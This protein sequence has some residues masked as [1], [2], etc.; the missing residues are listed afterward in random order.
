MFNIILKFCGFVLLPG[1]LLAPA[2]FADVLR[3]HENGPL[4]GIF[5]V[6]DSTEGAHLLRAGERAWDLSIT[7]ASHSMDDSQSV[8]TLYLDGETTR[9]ELR[10]RLGIGTRMDVGLELPYIQHQA[11]HLDSVIDSWHNLFGLPTGH[12]PGREQNVLDFRYA[13]EA[14]Q[15]VIVDSSSKG[16]GDARLFGG[17][18]LFSTERHQLAFRFGVKFPT[19]DSGKLHGSGGTDL[20]LGLAGDVMNLFGI[21]NLTGFYRIHAIH[22]GEP[23]LLAD[24]YEK[25]ASFISTGVGFQVSDRL[26][27]RLQGASRSALYQSEIH[28]LGG[29]ATTVTFGG[30]IRISKNYELS[31][32]VSEDAD[33][34][35]APDVAFQIALRYRE[36]GGQ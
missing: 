9:V 6:P 24:R 7:H 14:G 22:I 16:I 8:E 20:S 27:L 2:A 11:G 12:R 34:E 31:L 32:G 18:R 28:S 21:S 5:G 25:W 17:L 35:T 26:E 29:N 10:F 13:D 19:G 15:A 33:A 3:D 30:N 4:T 36:T 1:V 23:D